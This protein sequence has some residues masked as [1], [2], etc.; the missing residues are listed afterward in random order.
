MKERNTEGRWQNTA[1]CRDKDPDLFFPESGDQE[2]I[3]TAIGIRR[4]CPVASECERYWNEHRLT[5]GYPTSGIWAGIYH[6]TR[7]TPL[8][9]RDRSST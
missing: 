5:L 2:R 7:K 1:S 6:P 4:T 8:R 3:R 9:H